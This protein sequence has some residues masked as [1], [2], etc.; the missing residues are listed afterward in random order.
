MLGPCCCAALFSRCSVQAYCCGFSCRA[1]ALGPLASVIV[2]PGLYST[3]SVVVAH[4]LSC[5]R[6]SQ[7]RDRPRVSCIGRRIL[8]HRATWEAPTPHSVQKSTTVLQKLVLVSLLPSLPLP[9]SL[10]TRHCSYMH[11]AHFQ[12]TSFTLALPS[13]WNVLLPGSC[14]AN[15]HLLQV[16]AQCT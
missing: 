14:M 1:R 2:V 5:S 15:S 3:G 10:P 8:Y 11:Q 6:S 16:F 4:R 13:V 7:I 9:S 12:L